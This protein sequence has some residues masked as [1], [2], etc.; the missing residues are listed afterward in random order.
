MVIDYVDPFA[1]NGTALALR[2]AFVNETMENL[3][4][5]LSMDADLK[6]NYPLTP[7]GNGSSGYNRNPG[8]LDLS[9]KAGKYESMMKN[10]SDYDII[11]YV[12]ENTKNGDVHSLMVKK[13]ETKTFKMKR[14]DILTLVVGNNF[15]SFTKPANAMSE[16]TPSSNFERHFCDTDQNYR[17]SINLSYSVSHPKTGKNKFMVMGAKNG[18]VSLIDVHQ[19]L[20]DF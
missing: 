2:R 10:E 20:E 9:K 12:S 3:Y 1:N 18:Y 4:E 8:I 16:E 17:E 6:T 14:G 5:D 11:L 19:V 15:K 7:C 13:G